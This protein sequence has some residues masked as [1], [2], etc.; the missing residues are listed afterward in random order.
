MGVGAPATQFASSVMPVF[1]TMI[2]PASRR[3]FTSVA[4]YGGTNRSKTNAPP[5]VGIRV[6][7]MLSFNA[8][9]IPCSGPRAWPEARSSSRRSASVIASGLTVSAACSWCS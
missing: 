9:G 4:S 8:I 5:V 7:W 1:A 2:A 6:V 3:F